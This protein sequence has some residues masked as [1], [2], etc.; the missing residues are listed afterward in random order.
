MF[1]ERGL[2]EDKVVFLHEYTSNNY[3]IC[4][5]VIFEFMFEHSDIAS[6]VSVPEFTS[7]GIQLFVID[8][9]EEWFTDIVQPEFKID[10]F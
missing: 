7:S 2:I 8:L 4:F 3:Q 6:I 9:V 5:L 10:I 1:K